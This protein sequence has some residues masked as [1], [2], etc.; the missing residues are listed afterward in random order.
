MKNIIDI[1]IPGILQMEI[2]RNSRENIKEK[3]MGHI[4]KIIGI[5]DV[6]SIHES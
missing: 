2:S 5:N 4:G 6:Q 1:D 3:N